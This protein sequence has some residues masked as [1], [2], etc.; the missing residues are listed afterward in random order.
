MEPK[1]QITDRGFKILSCFTS[2]VET[3]ED[4]A[5]LKRQN[6]AKKAG[7]PNK[8]SST[9]YPTRLFTPPSGGVFVLFFVSSQHNGCSNNPRICA[10]E[11]RKMSEKRLKGVFSALGRTGAG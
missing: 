8:L 6:A 10:K 1:V 5:Q 9:G 3:Y 11:D 7:R 4:S 2:R